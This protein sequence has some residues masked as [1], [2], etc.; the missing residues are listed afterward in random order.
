M[1]RISVGLDFD[2]NDSKVVEYIGASYVQ[3]YV[4]I[5][6]YGEEAARLLTAGRSCDG[7]VRVS[8]IVG[9]PVESVSCNQDTAIVIDCMRD[10]N[11]AWGGT[12]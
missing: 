1:S 6:W 10:L 11:V 5:H 4:V 3:T 8:G 2:C 9:R 12:G 7:S